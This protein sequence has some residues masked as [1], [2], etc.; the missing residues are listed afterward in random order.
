[1]QPVYPVDSKR[2]DAQCILSF[3]C[4]QERKQR[5]YDRYVI[6]R[7]TVAL[8]IVARLKKIH[9]DVSDFCI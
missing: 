2:N 9:M 8:A 4:V 7:A 1:M 6:K 5:G 3:D